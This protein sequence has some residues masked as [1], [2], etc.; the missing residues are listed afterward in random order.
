MIIKKTYIWGIVLGLFALS[1]IAVSKSFGQ[2]GNTGGTQTAIVGQVTAIANKVI[3]LSDKKG[4]LVR[5]AT[6]GTT[7]IVSANNSFIDVH[8]G[9]TIAALTAA[10]LA[11]ESVSASQQVAAR[12]F[13]QEAS[14][15]AALPAVI[16]GIVTGVNDSI[17][18]VLVKNPG[19]TFYTL[20]IHDTTSVKAKGNVIGVADL[21]LGQQIVAVGTGKEDAFDTLLIY[22]F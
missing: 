18:T 3:T 6:N 10:S 16:T 17:V 21:V 7:K 15:S 22:A 13:V 20:V 19:E 9:D 4:G 1:L 8:I 2:V 5:V 11:T 14:A 12:L